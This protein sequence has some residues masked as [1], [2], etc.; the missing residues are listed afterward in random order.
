MPRL[1]TLSTTIRQHVSDERI[2]NLLCSALEGGSNYWYTIEAFAA[3]PALTFR[4]DETQ[5]FKHIDYPMSEGG[6][7]TI[8]DLEDS[9]A[10]FKHKILTRAVLRAGLQTMAEKYPSHYAE[11]VRENDDAETGDVFLQCCCFGEIIYG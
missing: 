11:F 3:P 9:G 7:I 2:A 8:G 5:V 1:R 4:T 10:K 6:S